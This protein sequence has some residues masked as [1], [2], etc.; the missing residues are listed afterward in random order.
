MHAHCQ[1]TFF[2]FFEGGKGQVGW[3]KPMKLIIKVIVVILRR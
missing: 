1:F 3:I 2:L